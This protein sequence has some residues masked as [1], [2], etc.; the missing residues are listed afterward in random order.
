MIFIGAISEVKTIW[1]LVDIVL[2]CMAVPHMAALMLY[3]HRKR[4]SD[5]ALGVARQ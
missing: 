4:K 1:S 2:A 5:E 3:A